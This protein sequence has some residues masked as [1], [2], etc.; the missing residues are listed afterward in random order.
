MARLG[1][2][3]LPA[4]IAVVAGFR[5]T[6]VLEL[7]ERIGSLIIPGQP[8]DKQALQSDVQ[9]PLQQPPEELVI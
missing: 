3:L 9:Q 1:A 8:K 6:M 7:M 2:R 4:A 5:Q